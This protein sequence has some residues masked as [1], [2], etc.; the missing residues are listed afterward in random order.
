MENSYFTGIMST[1]KIRSNFRSN[2]SELLKLCKLS[3]VV[4]AVIK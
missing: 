1:I 3:V 4:D 2:M